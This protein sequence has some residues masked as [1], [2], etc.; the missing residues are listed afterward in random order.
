[1]D[2]R[3]GSARRLREREALTRAP[4]ASAPLEARLTFV[5]EHTAQEPVPLVP[6]LVVHTATEVTPLWRATEEWLGARGVDV[7]F[8]SV[9]WAG[10]QAL[11]RWVLD[12]PDAVRGKRVL[13][14]GAGS[15]LVALACAKAGAQRVLAVDV[16]PLAEAACVLNARANGLVIDVRVEDLVGRALGAEVDVLVAGDV[17]YDRSASARFG[18]WLDSIVT[19]GVRVVTG[20]PGRTYVPDA[21]VELA[22][23]EVP[24]REDLESRPSRTTRVLELRGLRAGA[25]T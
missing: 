5:A 3:A 21:A 6:E 18:P 22:R 16:D 14:F 25:R 4:L 20:D 2:R 1:V 19:E 17:W 13:D 24:T 7:P 11:A 15:G 8:W 12:H 23:Y 9:P 10:G